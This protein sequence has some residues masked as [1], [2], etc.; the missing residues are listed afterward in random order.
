[1]SH[2]RYGA[3]TM[4][5]MTPTGSSVGANTRRAT[6]SET[7]N[8][9]APTSA[10]GT[11]VT[12][13]RRDSDQRHGDQDQQRLVAFDG[14]SETLRCVVAELQRPQGSCEYQHCGE[15]HQ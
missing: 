15:Q 8:S 2:M 4:P 7:S 14:D 9:N 3:P 1:M 12:G 11:K 5:V 6:R 13:G 10:A